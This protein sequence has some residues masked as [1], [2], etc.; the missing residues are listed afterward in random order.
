MVVVV[1]VVVL[2]VAGLVGLVVVLSP[3]DFVDSGWCWL[4]PPCPPSISLEIPPQF[5]LPE[6]LG[7]TQT[8]N[9]GEKTV[10]GPQSNSK[11]V[12]FL[13]PWSTHL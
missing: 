4:E 1:V 2:V 3:G 6:S 7:W 10:P 9:S 12:N 5:S 8:L 13:P 11:A